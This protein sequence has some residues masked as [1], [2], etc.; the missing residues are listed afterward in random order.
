MKVLTITIIV[1]CVFNLTAQIA[2]G[3]M[4]NEWNISAIGG[5]FIALLAEI[6]LLDN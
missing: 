2:I 3:F 6:Q 5:W 4:T 1:L